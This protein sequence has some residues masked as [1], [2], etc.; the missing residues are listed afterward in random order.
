MPQLKPASPVAVPVSTPVGEARVRFDLPPR[1]AA[2]LVLGHG[3]GGGIEAPDLAA[4]CRATV[5]ADIAV[6]RVEQP[7]RVVGRRTP[8][9]AGA[10]DAAWTAVVRALP[11]LEPGLAELPRVVGGRSSGARVACRTA[12]ALDAAAVVALA[13]PV[14]P[15]RRPPRPPAPNR[16]AELALP[17][18]PVLV[19][20]GDRDPFGMPPPAPG[21]T[22]AVIP[23]GDHSLRRQASAVGAAVVDWLTTGPGAIVA[24]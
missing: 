4:V 24:G 18:V 2:L 3:A 13:F 16:L 1:P 19:V 9:Q 7:Y 11:G 5:A 22:V 10:L 23:G 20:Q 6:V 17:T 15:P 21:R 12:S 8:P 14:Q